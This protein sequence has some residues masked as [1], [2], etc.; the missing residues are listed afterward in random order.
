MPYNA[1]F[2]RQSLLSLLFL[3][4]F[5][6]ILAV[7]PLFAATASNKKQKTTQKVFPNTKIA[8]NYG[9]YNIGDTRFK[10]V[11]DKGG[12]IFGLEAART[13]IE[14]SPHSLSVSVGI[15]YF[16]R[17]GQATVTLE[18]SRL[19]LIPVHLGIRYGLKIK[20]YF[21]WLEAGFIVCPYK[22]SSDIKSSRGT[23]L[24]YHIQS[25][26]SVKPSCLKGLC[27]TLFVRHAKLMAEENGIRVNLGGFEFGAG[28]GFFFN[29]F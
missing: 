8:L 15:R 6:I 11:Y 25:G 16:S 19:T 29:L 3:T 14:G 1:R 2:K 10:K 18:D 13:F 20:S 23:S 24:G 27:F 9:R 26:L 4:T 17:K 28:M 12:Q 21:P 5:A 7:S 22:E